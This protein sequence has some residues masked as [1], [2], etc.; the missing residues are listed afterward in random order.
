MAR[1]VGENMVQPL[2]KTKGVETGNKEQR[3]IIDRN[4]NFADVKTNGVAQRMFDRH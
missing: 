3:G 1:L 4:N 2:H